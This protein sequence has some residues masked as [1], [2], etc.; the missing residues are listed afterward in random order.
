MS[1]SR[2]A[3]RIY[4]AAAP[5]VGS[6]LRGWRF[7]ARRLPR[8]GLTYRVL[9]HDLPRIISCRRPLIFDV[10]ANKGQTIELMSRVFPDARVHAF[11]PAR[12]LADALRDEY[13]HSGVVVQSV[14]LG[15]TEGSHR[16]T[17]Y[18]NNELSSL[19][20]LERN[21]SNPFSGVAVE[22]IEDVA[23]TTIDSYCRSKGIHAVDLL[24]IDTQGFDLEVL[25]GAEGMFVRGAIG[26]V[27]VEMN[28]IPLYERQPSPGV[29]IDWLGAHGMDFVCLYEQVRLETAVSWATA[30]FVRAREP[31][32]GS[33]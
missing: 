28:F 5:R 1:L 17:R 22:A 6:F 10:G 29:V 19:L 26:V 11:E 4:D 7:D 27:L 14:A 23:V 12:E 21:A 33:A 15:A 30:C 25:R 9:E 16:F 13:A 2:L 18:A 8:S 32:A 24:K 3:H 31:I 20:T